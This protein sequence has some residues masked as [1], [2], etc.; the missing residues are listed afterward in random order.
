MEKFST[1]HRQRFMK[2]FSRGFLFFLV[3]LLSGCNSGSNPDQM[4]GY[5]ETGSASFSIEWQDAAVNPAL[6]MSKAQSV[7]CA[8]IEYIVCEVYDA[9]G[10][11]LTTAIFDCTAGQGTIDN[12]P[13]GSG[14]RFVILCLDASGEIQSRGQVLGVTISKGQTNDLGTIL[15]EPFFVSTL[16]SPGDESSVTADDLSFQWQPVQYASEYYLMVSTD[17]NFDEV[18]L[19]ISTPDTYFTPSST[20]ASGTYYW[21]VLPVDAYL[22]HGA[23]SPVWSFTALGDCTYTITPASTALSSG[24]NSGSIRVT[25][26]AEH[27]TW[28]ASSSAD[29]LTITSGATGIADGSVYYAVPANT[30]ETTRT[31]T[32]AVAGQTHTITQAGGAAPDLVITSGDPT[33]TPSA[34]AP[35]GSLTVRGWTEENQGTLSADTYYYGIYLSPNSTISDDDTYLAGGSTPGLEAGGI[36]TR[37]QK[38]VTIPQDT[39]EGTYYIGVLLDRD[40][41]I[42]ELDESNNYV[43]QQITVASFVDLVIT[44]GSPT[45]TPSTVYAGDDV[46][47]SGWTVKNQ[48]TL[49]SGMFYNAFYFSTDAVITENDWFLDSNANA[50]LAGNEEF[51]WGERPLTIPTDIDSG[52]YYIGILLDQYNLVYESSETNNYVSQQITVIV[53][54]Q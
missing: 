47:L 15:V 42:T 39:P 6:D 8:F 49:P 11:D 27:C 51:D 9:S 23:S 28:S 22:N 7:N 29:W 41:D 12:I 2:Y 16:L 17:S 13:V 1:L 35:G 45:V 4:A 31:A 36:Y 19:N 25:S 54:E 50:S 38:T 10:N 32:I 44:T 53:G 46:T 18:I 34:V 3:C 5:I 48:G 37:G 20:L 43:S 33:V 26:S 52:T 24:A 14:I 40:D 21:M 30:S